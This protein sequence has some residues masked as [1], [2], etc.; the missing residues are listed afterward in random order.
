MLRNA[1]HN[2]SISITVPIVVTSSILL[3]LL[4]SAVWWLKMRV[5]S[6]A[7]YEPFVAVA[8]AVGLLAL[9]QFGLWEVAGLGSPYAVKKHG[10]MIGTF[11]AASLAVCVTQI[12][13]RILLNRQLH[14]GLT[15]LPISVMRW[16]TACLAV[17]AVLPWQ[18]EPLAPVIRYDSAARAIAAAG[19]PTDLLGRTTSVN[20]QLPL[21][22]NFAVALAV[23]HLPGWTPAATDQF[24]AFGTEEPVASGVRYA[25]VASGLPELSLT[26]VVR[27]YPEMQVK[28]VRRDCVDNSIR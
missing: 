1:A 9:I 23:L 20:R 13:V 5:E 18:G 26:C 27:A 25:L 7:L 6:A 8:I 4:A 22:I 3:L 16:V 14:I 21:A 12:A 19:N 24:A 2:G 17:V 15:F 11:I 28:L 10:F